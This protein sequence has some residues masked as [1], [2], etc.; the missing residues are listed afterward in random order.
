[1][2]VVCNYDNGQICNCNLKNYLKGKLFV[3]CNRKRAF[4]IAVCDIIF[5]SNCT[6]SQFLFLWYIE[7]E[8]GIFE[9]V[10]QGDLDFSSD[11]WPS[12]SDGA[13]DLVRRMLMRDPKKRL[14]AHEVLCEFS[15][16]IGWIMGS[17]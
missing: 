16:F 2:S 15:S 7:T 9:Q 17:G 1:M 4:S 6:H 3:I 5:I 11:P 12:I 13:K 8:Q 10:L 14:T